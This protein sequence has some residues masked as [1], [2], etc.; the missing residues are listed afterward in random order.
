MKKL[1]FLFLF[2]LIVQLDLL[3]QPCFP[4]DISLTSQA[5]IDSFAIQYP[6][7][8]EIA[9]DLKIYGSDITNLDGLNVITSVGS[10]LYIGIDSVGNPLLTDISGLIKVSHIGY[11]LFIQNNPMLETLAGLDSIPSLN[12]SCHIENN[13]SLFSFE[14]LNIQ[15]IRGFFILRNNPLITD[16]DGLSLLRYVMYDFIVDN[17]DSLASFEGLDE[18]VQITGS[19]GIMNNDQLINL[20]GLEQLYLLEQSLS[21][22]NNP[23][24]NDISSLNQVEELHFDLHISGN[25]SLDSLTGLEKIENID[26]FIFIYDNNSL[27]SL[28]GLCGLKELGGKLEIV[29]NLRL[30]N[31]KGLENLKTIGGSL[32]LENTNSESQEQLK[33]LDGLENLEKIGGS[34]TITNQPLLENLSALLN[35]E[36]VGGSIN[37]RNNHTLSSLYGLDNIQASSIQLLYIAHNPKLSTCEVKSICDYLEIPGE[38]TYIE[39]NSD[40]C[41]NKTQIQEACGTVGEE[42]IFEQNPLIYPNPASDKLFISMNADQ[43]IN[44]IIIYNNYG[45]KVFH[46]A[47]TTNVIDISKLDQ[48]VY[49]LELKSNELTTREKLIIK[50]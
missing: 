17:N 26:R 33:C 44:D 45:Q 40:G 19:L 14:H 6:N 25:R 35:L 42:T 36:S 12:C 15:V 22:K 43:K 37:I 18:L 38:S 10:D 11:K 16:M 21:I 24:L 34:L 13:A 5:Q 23:L 29:R 1:A 8:T 39:F 46:K 9:N 27:V 49:I 48:G 20:N 32:V 31:L 50:K 3:S 28:H 2:A 30:S 4:Y 7:C 47:L 41:N